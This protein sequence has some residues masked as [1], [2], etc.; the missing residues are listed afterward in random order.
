MVKIRK[1]N[2]PVQKCV[3]EIIKFL[4]ERKIST[5]NEFNSRNFD[6]SEV[7]RIIDTT[8]RDMNEF[9]EIKFYLKLKL[10]SVSQLNKMLKPYLDCEDYEKCTLLRNRISELSN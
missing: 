8:A 4:Y 1:I 7:D 9:E 5:W 10:C 6:R 2:D 3:E